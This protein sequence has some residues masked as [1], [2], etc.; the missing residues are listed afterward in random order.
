MTALVLIETENGKIRQAARSAV[1]AARRFGEVDILLFSPEGESG[2]EEAASLPGVRK[3]YHVAARPMAETAASLVAE[4]AGDYSHIVAPA[5]SM[6]KNV[7]PR[8][9]G[10]LDVQPITDVVEIVDD[11]TFV[12]PIY[13]GN[14]LAT[15]RSE[16]SVKLLTVRGSSFAPIQNGE[17]EKAPIETL[18]SPVADH[19]RF[20]RLELVESDRP[21]LESARIVISGGKGLKDAAH[22]HAL[23]EPVAD[24]LKAAIGASRAAVDSGFAPNEMQVGQTG[25]IVAPELYIAVGLSGALQHLAGMKDS[26]V[27]VAINMDPDAPIFRVADYGIVGDLFEILP[28]LEKSL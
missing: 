1:T 12:R 26:R 2:A 9:A 20:V 24:K 25:K 14:A 28:Q 27:I 22:F 4:R 3:V 13:A 18:E 23:L 5:S 17:G 19:A 21:D 6:G 10:L 11:A 16:D 8:A 7:L 15:V